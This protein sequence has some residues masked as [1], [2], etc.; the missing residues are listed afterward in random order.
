MRIWDFL[1]GKKTY[2]LAGTLLL[3]ALGLLLA[4][5][6]SPTA[7]L[8]L[9]SVAVCGFPATFRQALARH[10]QEEL[11]LLEE[12]AQTGAA[13]MAHNMKVAAAMGELAAL[14]GAHLASECKDEAQEAKNG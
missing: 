3:I 9:V 2:L 1:A 7:V 14:D 12:I 8:F 13:L 11:E 10:Q 4:G 6:M 5:R